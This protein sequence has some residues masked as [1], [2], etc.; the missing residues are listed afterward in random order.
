MRPSLE[1]LDQSG[2]AQAVGEAMELLREPG[3]RV[4]DK[5]VLKLLASSG[6]K[7]AEGV[8]RIPEALVE[9]ALRSVP[10][11]FYLYDRAGQATVRYGGDA[12]Q[13]DPGSSCVN[14]LDAETQQPRPARTSD[15]VR[16]VQIAEVLP[17]YAAQSTAVVCSDV[18]PALGD[19]YRL[20]LVL[21]HSSKPIVTGAFGAET[22]AAMLKLLEADAGQREILQERPRAIFDVCPS[23]PLNWSE[24]GAENLVDLAR[25]AV[26]AEIVPAP[27]AGATSPVTLAGTVAQHTAECLSGIVIHQMA[28]AGAP[29]VWGGAPAIFD[30]RTGA[31]PWG[32]METAMLSV[33]CAQ[34]GKHLGVPTHAYLVTSDAKSMDAQC[35]LE[36]GAS[37]VLGALAGINMISGAGMLESLSCHSAEKLAM[38]ADA[39]AMAQRLVQGITAAS[40]PSAPAMVR[41]AEAR[42]GFLKL[43][44][45]RKLFRQEQ[46]MPSEILDRGPVRPLDARAT[47]AFARARQRVRELEKAYQRPS[48]SPALERAW[49][50]I[51]E[52][53]A[54]SAGLQELPGIE[55][56]T[57]PRL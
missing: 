4:R 52:P 18:P 16:L 40:T 12:V 13:F 33:A 6:A 54:H 15:L 9:R 29:V 17:Q 53:A 36:S 55:M 21:W 10:R 46:F 48:V 41:E 56:P 8:A 37:A 42:G 31:T 20:F 28:R 14:I 34:V 45:T 38:D 43:E 1:L 22:L 30:M 3:I 7:V 23:S 32:A 24:F 49:L 25:A 2:I 26:P 11:E 44:A 19:L 57:A 51:V 39:I 5:R 35:G 47:D 50:D 27:M